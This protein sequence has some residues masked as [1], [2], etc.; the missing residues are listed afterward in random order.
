MRHPL[1]AVASAALITLTAPC[2]VAAQ[3]VGASRPSALDS[4]ST[5][6]VELELERVS[7]TAVVSAQIGPPRDLDARIAVLHERLGALPEGA[8]ADREANR[9]VLLALDAR[10]ASVQAKIHEARLI[11]TDAN[12]VVRR[13]LS[14]QRAIDERRSDIRRA[15]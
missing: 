14:E 12:P 5:R 11:S 7:A 10:A 13:L 8:T 9:R 1:L 4:L 15:T 2:I 3:Q 6:L